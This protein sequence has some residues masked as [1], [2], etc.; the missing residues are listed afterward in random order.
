VYVHDL[1]IH[2]TTG[3]MRVATFGRGAFEV[4][5]DSPIGSVL[6]AEGRVALLRVH[7]LGTKYGPPTDQIDVEAVIWL[8]SEPGKAFGFQLRR[9]ANESAHRGMLDFL[10]D[11]FNRDRHIRIEYVRT[12]LRTGRIFRT[13]DIP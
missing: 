6:S 5:T 10:R 9:D 1:E 7:D 11:A 2:P 8:D 3:V 4:N 12:G 13:I